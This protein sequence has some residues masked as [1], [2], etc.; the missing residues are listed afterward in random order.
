[1]S[2]LEIVATRVVEFVVAH[3]LEIVATLFGAVCVYLS[4]R[5]SVWTWPTGLVNVLLFVVV[6]WQARLYA[7]MGLQVL[8]AGASI[9]GWW[10]WLHGG[11]AG[12]ELHVT[13][14]PVRWLLGLFAAGAVSSVALGTWLQAHTNASLPYLD[15]SLSS[16]SVVA[17]WQMT[18][19]WIENWML[20]IVLNAVYVGMFINKQLYPTA[21]QY[22]LFLVLAVM[23]LRDWARSMEEHSP[24]TT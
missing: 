14:T 20:W 8:Y 13:R 17:Q 2:A 15:A 24:T 19:K 1:M 23:G 4:V 18:R 10:A 11:Q 7:D 22:A 21:A 9:Y 6:F 16:F 3:W 5:Q 12:G